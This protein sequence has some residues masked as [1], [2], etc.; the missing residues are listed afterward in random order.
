MTPIFQNMAPKRLNNHNL[1]RICGNASIK[2]G[3]CRDKP[4]SKTV[5]IQKPKSGVSRQPGRILTLP[6][7]VKATGDKAG[8]GSPANPQPSRLRVLAASRCHSWRKCQDAPRQPAFNRFRL[9]KTVQGLPFGPPLCTGLRQQKKR[10]A[11]A[12]PKPVLGRPL[13]GFA[14]IPG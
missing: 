3:F 8:L 13:A 4:L 6:P 5:T 2:P 9:L 12:H 1:A 11:V 14:P 7:N 10:M